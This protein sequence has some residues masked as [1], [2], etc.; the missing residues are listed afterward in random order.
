[1]ASEAQSCPDCGE[2]SF[3]INQEKGEVIC[4][5]CSY[6]IDDAMI[7]FGRERFMDSEDLEKN[8]RSGAPFDPTITNNL[9]TQVGT[10]ADLSK[11]PQNIKYMV[12]RIRKKNSWTS[13]SIENNL[14][15]SLPQLKMICSYL[16]MPASV[17]KEAARIYRRGVEK[18]LTK[19]RSCEGV[20][21]ASVYIASR[22]FGFPTTI[23]DIG[24]TTKLNKKS[25][26]K[27]Y[28][29]VLRELNIK[30][31]PSNPLDYIA[32]YASLLELSPKTQSR[33]VEIA[34]EAQK[35]DIT[36]GVSPVTIAATSLYLAALQMK[37]RRTQ[38]AVTD[39]TQITEVTLRTRCKDFVEALK[40]KV[41]V[42]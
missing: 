13:S 8:S 20:I 6:V 27:Y 21:V 18:G 42:R 15:R 23:K 26:G 39:M 4:R 33:A 19:A 17:E 34:E 25:I 37:E 41:K 36:S 12:K 40:L 14:N 2:H 29:L 30:I 38:K 7:D 28:K 22:M 11:L 16:K 32:K 35:K 24:E 9:M 3:F 31:E 10:T 5:E 1:M